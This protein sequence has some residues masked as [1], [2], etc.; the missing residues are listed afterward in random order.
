M[1]VPR[2]FGFIHPGWF[3]RLGYLGFVPPYDDLDVPFLEVARGEALV[4]ATRIGIK[5]PDVSVRFFQGA[6]LGLQLPFVSP[7]ERVV[8]TNLMK[9]LP[10]F[11]FDLPRGRPKMCAD[12]RNGKLA[13]TQPVIHTIVIDPDERRLTVLWAGTAPALRPYTEAELAKMPLLVEW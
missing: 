5:T 4:E 12:G 3:P 10:S 8:L 7:G 9:G 11:P 6:S 1:P 13:P 2:S